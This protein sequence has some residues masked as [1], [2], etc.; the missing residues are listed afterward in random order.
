MKMIQEIEP[1]KFNNRFYHRDIKETDYYICVKDNKVAYKVIDENLSLPSVK[2]EGIFDSQFLFCIDDIGFYYLDKE[3]TGYEYGD[4]KTV[5]RLKPAHIRFALIE[6]LRL[7]KWYKNNVY[8]GHCGTKTI[9][10]DQERMLKCPK[11]NNMIY[12]RIN[13][14]CIVGI[15]NNGKILLTKYSDKSVATHY[16]LVAG[17]CEF[18][19]TAEQCIAREVKEET[20]LSIKNIKYVTS[21]SWPM[22]ESLIFG[23]YCELDGQNN[24]TFNDHEL[25]T[26]IWFKPEDIKEIEAPSVTAYLINNFKAKGMDVL[27]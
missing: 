27:K 24:V 12:P 20:G 10:S 18:G 4:Y 13:P 11:C 8:C 1:Y 9:H 26:A 25:D 14:V 19:E 16:A 7:V 6:G 23:F 17:F 2:D 22:S 3:L 21:Q 15:I 5:S